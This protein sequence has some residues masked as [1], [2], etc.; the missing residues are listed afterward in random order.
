MTERRRKPPVIA[1]WIIS[2]LSLYEERFALSDLIEEEFLDIRDRKGKIKAKTWYWIQLFNILI[3]CIPSSFERSTAMFKN[4]VKIAYRIIRRNSGYSFINITGLAL[5]MACCMIILLIVQNDLE[6]EG[7]HSNADMLFQIKSISAH[8]PYPLAPHLEDNY[9][10]IIETARFY[11]R[12]S[13]I[14]F[15]KKT[16]EENNFA[17]VDP[18]F[19]DLF[20]FPLVS[21]DPVTALEKPYSLLL[22]EG[23]AKKYFGSDDPVGKVLKCNNNYGLQVTGV[24]K[25]LPDNTH[26]EFEFLASFETLES[27]GISDF[28][29]FWGN[30]YLFSYV[31][32]ENNVDYLSLIPKIENTVIEKVPDLAISEKL[33]LV[34]IKDIHLYEN[35]AIKY[36]YIFSAIA[37]F[38][39]IV[40]IVNFINLTTAR[41]NTRAREIGV[42]KVIGSTRFMLANQFLGES[43]L[44]SVIA[45]SVALAVTIFSLPI[46]NTNAGLNFSSLLVFGNFTILAMLLSVI[47]FT[48]IAA[49]IYPALFL[50]GFDPV[51]LVKGSGGGNKSSG[52]GGRKKLVLFQFTISTA[53]IIST[54]VIYDQLE[55]INRMNL[56]FEK[57]HLVYIRLKPPVQENSDSFKNELMRDPYIVDVCFASSVPSAVGNTGS[58]MD[59]DGKPEDYN[60]TWPFFSIDYDFLPAVG[61]ELVEGRNFSEEM[62]T[63][64]RTAYILNQK[65]VETMGY[66]SPVGRR[67]ALWGNEGKIIG[68]VKNFH[69]RSAH[70]EIEPVMFLIMPDFYYNSII[71]IAPGSDFRKTFS[72]I[73]SVWNK[74]APD[75]PFEVR[76]LDESLQR[77]YESEQR[78]STIFRIFTFLTL[79][80]SCLGLFG[81]VACI[82]EQR[83]REIGIR[84]TLGAGMDNILVLV[85]REFITVVVASNIIA[86][87]IAYYL[88]S[89]WLNNF[90]Y[91]AEISFMLFFIALLTAVILTIFTIGFQVIKAARANPVDSLRYE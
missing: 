55:Y 26:F 46:V 22:T 71:R 70:R 53:L 35:G 75:F 28:Q 57:D 49:G 24:L 69:C 27:E 42:R 51:K 5:G 3:Q 66:E 47:L 82:T 37:V 74:F 85:G 78:M 91:H 31:Q 44:I 6:Y 63:D 2:K 84:K 20:N 48:G 25:D 10:E 11:N 72:Y 83:T 12:R 7:F 88:M 15:Q 52:V 17:Y 61:L 81:L 33:R 65:A 45:G 21:G 56:G 60:P 43:A 1:K 64:R 34:P 30:H 89:R 77:Y 41:V 14:R 29:K 4:Y 73:E 62:K 9:P 18:E 32:L 86:F 19:L 13:T 54:C 68:V 16:F 23:S 50:S 36:V 58:G 90:A 59:W 8:Q 38:I 39:L 67:F 80:I 76:F 40:A 79:L 87:P